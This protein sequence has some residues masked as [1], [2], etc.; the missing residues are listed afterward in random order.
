MYIE[1]PLSVTK[2]TNKHVYH[3]KSMF[4]SWN[5]MYNALYTSYYTFSFLH[6]SLFIYFMYIIT[7][8]SFMNFF[9]RFVRI[10]LE[11]FLTTFNFYLKLMSRKFSFSSFYDYELFGKIIRSIRTHDAMLEKRV[12]SRSTRVNVKSLTNNVSRRYMEK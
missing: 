12:Y 11:I 1:F 5:F 6:N 2:Y 3:A 10:I 7:K 8:L 4:V 9:K